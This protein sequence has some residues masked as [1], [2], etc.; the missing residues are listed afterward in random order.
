MDLVGRIGRELFEEGTYSALSEG[1]LPYPE[2]NA[3]F[4]RA[5]EGDEGG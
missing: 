1:A 5:P 4:A 3:L 2:A